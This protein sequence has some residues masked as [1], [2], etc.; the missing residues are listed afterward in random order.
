MKLLKLEKSKFRTCEDTTIKKVLLNI[1]DYLIYGLTD[2]NYF[3][4]N[5][6]IDPKCD[7]KVKDHTL[8]SVFYSKVLSYHIIANM[9]CVKMPK[10]TYNLNPFKLNWFKK[11]CNSL[12]EY[13]IANDIKEIHTPIFGTKI[14]EGDWQSILQVMKET[15]EN[16]PLE[17]LYI[18]E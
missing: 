15:F 13:I 10:T 4:R 1:C 5:W 3:Y 16:T 12:K 7:F 14:L 11:C 17:R 6:Y 9:V 2:T 18:Y 8:G